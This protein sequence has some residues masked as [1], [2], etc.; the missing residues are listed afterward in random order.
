MHKD[1]ET[2]PLLRAF[3]IEHLSPGVILERSSRDQR[4]LIS[5]FQLRWDAFLFEETIPDEY[6]DDGRTDLIALHA[7]LAAPAPEATIGGRTAWISFQGKS[8][9][10]DRYRYGFICFVSRGKQEHLSVTFTRT[11][12]AILTHRARERKHDERAYPLAFALWILKDRLDGGTVQADEVIDPGVLAHLSS[13][14]T[15]RDKEV[16]SYVASKLYTAYQI[17]GKDVRLLFDWTDFEYLGISEDDFNRAVSLCEGEDWTLDGF[18]LRPTRRLLQQCDEGISSVHT[19]DQQTSPLPATHRDVFL[20]H[21]SEDKETFVRPLVT[22]LTAA[23][24]SVWYDEYE[25]TIGDSLRRSIE[26]GLRRS[27]HGLVVISHNFFRKDWPQREL[28]ALFAL[29]EQG[30]RILPIWHDLTREEVAA[31]SP[32]LADIIAVQSSKGMK[33]IVMAVKQ[34]LV[35]DKG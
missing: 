10:G 34:A 30:K 35:K 13:R 24:V 8:M 9:P 20:S 5:W 27:R 1:P 14:S 23:G 32:L 25:L 33:E 19:L 21:A 29:A 4:R 26:G 3:V 17:A 28:D 31:Y 2:A 16:R 7:K 11:A 6:W 18:V 12:H 15:T 22:A